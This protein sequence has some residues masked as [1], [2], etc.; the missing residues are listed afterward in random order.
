MIAVVI[1][2]LLGPTLH[3]TLGSLR[4]Q[5][6]QDF[7]VLLVNDSKLDSLEVDDAWFHSHVHVL[8]GPRKGWAGPPR[9]V[10]IRQAKSMGISWIAFVDDDDYLHPKY[11]EW[12]KEHQR[13]TPHADIIVFRARGKFD[14]IPETYAIPPA[15]CIHLVCGLITN[16]FALKTENCLEYDEGNEDTMAELYATKQHKGPGE[17]I[18]YLRNAQRQQKIIMFSHRLTYGVRMPINDATVFP[19]V[20]LYN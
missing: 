4:M 16:S 10:A 9:N 6:N 12:L 3:E 19:L 8:K 7:I 2:S 20:Q 18:A 13:I 11:I 17:D 15:G 14:H 1:P 5:T